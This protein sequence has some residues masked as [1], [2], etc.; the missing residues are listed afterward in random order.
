MEQTFVVINLS[1][2]E[3]FSLLSV[4]K[5]GFLLFLI[6]N[7]IYIYNT[8]SLVMGLSKK[9]YNRNVILDFLFK[10]FCCETLQKY[11]DF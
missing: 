1:L 3:Y 10:H 2:Q 7:I 6:C 5:Q 4:L 9:V 11:A 8:L